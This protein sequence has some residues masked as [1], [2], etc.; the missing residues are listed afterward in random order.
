MLVTFIAHKEGPHIVQED[1][2]RRVRRFVKS[3]HILRH[4]GLT[5]CNVNMSG[6][7]Y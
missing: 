1:N 2:R 6:F 7:F 5:L 4:S 3:H